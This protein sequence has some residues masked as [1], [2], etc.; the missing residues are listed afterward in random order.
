MASIVI[1]QHKIIGVQWM[2]IGLVFVGIFIEM[3]AAKSQPKKPE[4]ITTKK[5]H[6][7]ETTIEISGS[8]VE[9]TENIIK[10]ESPL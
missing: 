1:Y 5:S 7:D 10:R 3:F 9:E 6:N 2:A 4:P 8:N